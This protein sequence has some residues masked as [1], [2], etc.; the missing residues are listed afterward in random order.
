M[1]FI[2]PVCKVT[3]YFVI[4]EIL[5][6][7]LQFKS[8]LVVIFFL[9]FFNKVGQQNLSRITNLKKY[10]SGSGLKVRDV[11]PREFSTFFGISHQK[12]KGI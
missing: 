12:D 9:Q 2:N 6:E 5:N 11:F 3:A 8:P 1:C 10:V 7:I 4:S